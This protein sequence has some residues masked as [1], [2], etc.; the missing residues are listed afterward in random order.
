M[1]TRGAREIAKRA[2]A[3]QRRTARMVKDFPMRKGSVEW[4]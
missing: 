4:A 2:F 3:E 1:V